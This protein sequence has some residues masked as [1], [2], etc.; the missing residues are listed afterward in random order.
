M[1][2]IN[3]KSILVEYEEF[4][5]LCKNHLSKGKKIPSKKITNYKNSNKP[6]TEQQQKKIIAKFE[7]WKRNFL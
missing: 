2:D 3:H 5:K 7:K 6:M 4:E 1:E